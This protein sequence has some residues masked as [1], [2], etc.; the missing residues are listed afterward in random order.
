MSYELLG[1][2]FQPMRL[3]DS[4]VQDCILL[5]DI[6]EIKGAVARVFNKNP[7]DIPNDIPLMSPGGFDSRAYVP[8]KIH[9]LL[10]DGSLV[11]DTPWGEP[12]VFPPGS[13]CVLIPSYASSHLKE[14]I[15]ALQKDVDRVFGQFTKAI[16]ASQN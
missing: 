16:Q 1:G 11:I 6:I 2:T 9:P 8:G 4:S 15:F 14:A 13:N 3:E 5:L 10:S 7:N 12:R